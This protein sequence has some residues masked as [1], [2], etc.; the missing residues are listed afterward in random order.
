MNTNYIKPIP[1]RIEKHILDYDATHNDYCGLRFYSYLT[2]IQKELV[3]IT[4]AVRNKN[5]K[6]KAYKAGSHSRRILGQ[7]PCQGYGIFLYGQLS[8]RLV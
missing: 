8:C 1:K 7:V 6:N 4:V 5:K 3:K 2:T